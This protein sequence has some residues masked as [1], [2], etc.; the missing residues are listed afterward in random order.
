MENLIYIDGHY[1]TGMEWSGSIQG[2][3]P[4]HLY[5][6]NVL[7]IGGAYILSVFQVGL[8]IDHANFEQNR[9]LKAMSNL[10]NLLYLT[11]HFASKIGIVYLDGH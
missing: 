9:D 10:L 2:M 4:V 5:L 3:E 7:F 1:F 8:A 6:P 11:A